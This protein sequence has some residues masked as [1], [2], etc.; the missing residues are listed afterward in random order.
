MCAKL[1]VSRSGFYAWL[2]RAPSARELRD[3]MLERRVVEHFEESNGVY[4]S[5]RIHALLR[6]RGERVGRKRVA[7]LMRGLHLKARAN[8]IYWKRS[9]GAVTCRLGI[10]NQARE[11]TVTG[12]DQVWR[13][14][15]T[16]LRSAGRWR[17]LAVVIDQYSRRLLGYQL[18]M[19]RTS[20]L[21]VAA[22][23]RAVTRR[24]P[25]P[26]LVFHSDRGSEY[27]GYLYR[28]RLARSGI[29]QSMN[30]PKTM[31]D[32]AHVES[33]FHS[34][35]TEAI[36]GRQFGSVADVDEAVRRYIERYNRTRVHSA[37]GYLSPVDYERAN[38]RN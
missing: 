7:R 15:I 1:E 6:R 21:T 38:A 30:R 13:G 25:A 17:Y 19:E 34:L 28:D 27:G 24:K 32:N 4:G 22:L 20:D 2:G 18:G 23:R 33:F 3:R 9:G 11:R 14:D 8:R 5:P 12:P 26:G 16:Y 35:K 37:L 10:G 29:V 31:T 36:H